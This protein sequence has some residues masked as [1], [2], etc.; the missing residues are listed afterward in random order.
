MR[1]CH[2]GGGADGACR[3]LRFDRLLLIQLGLEPQPHRTERRD[4]DGGGCHVTVRRHRMRNHL[5]EVPD[6]ACAVVDLG[7]GVQD[8]LPDTLRGQPDLV[9]WAGLEE[10]LVMQAIIWPSPS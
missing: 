2:L 10:K 5:S 8:L 3:L 4:R 1:R 9:V 6:Q 7:V